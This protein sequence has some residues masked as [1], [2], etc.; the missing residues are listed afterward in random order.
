MEAP[1]LCSAAT[2]L[3]FGLRRL[4]PGAGH[5]NHN[6]GCDRSRP[7][8]ALTPGSLAGQPGWGGCKVSA[9]QD[10]QPFPAHK[11]RSTATLPLPLAKAF[12]SCKTRHERWPGE[13]P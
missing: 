8:K 6:D 5:L 4:D 10:S 7:A 1:S 2:C 3:R 11:H 12:D 13:S 9:L